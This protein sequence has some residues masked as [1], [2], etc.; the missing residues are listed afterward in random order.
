[1]SRIVL[2][3]DPAGAVPA[4]VVVQIA[5]V[6]GTALSETKAAILS[7]EPVLDLALFDRK[8]PLG[9]TRILGLLRALDEKEIGYRAC[10]LTDDTAYDANAN[11]FEIDAIKLENMID[12]H[13]VSL[14][15]QRTI[16]WLEDPE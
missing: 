7:G 4:S 8:D 9:T 10:E 1:M 11:H 15:Y 16:G 3:I 12:A 6:S 14:S 13:R 5:R 2:M